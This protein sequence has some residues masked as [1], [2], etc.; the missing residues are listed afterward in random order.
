MNL[1]YVLIVCLVIYTSGLELNLRSV[2]LFL[3]QNNIANEKINF[4]NLTNK[5]ETFQIYI[6]IQSHFKIHN[7]RSVGQR[8]NSLL[9]LLRLDLLNKQLDEELSRANIQQRMSIGIKIL[10][11]MGSTM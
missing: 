6:I 5:T 7:P 1:K 2:T 11:L 8:Q 4:N 3:K 10:K 9:K